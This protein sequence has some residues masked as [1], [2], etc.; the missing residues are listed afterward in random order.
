[1]YI[2]PIDF[3]VR[4]IPIDAEYKQRKIEMDLQPQSTAYYPYNE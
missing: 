1:M 2:Q 4:I 3:Y